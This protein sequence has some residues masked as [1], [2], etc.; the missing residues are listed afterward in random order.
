MS[1]YFNC[2]LLESEKMHYICGSSLT[3]ISNEL[4]CAGSVYFE[5]TVF[6][7]SAGQVILM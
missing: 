2:E 7:Y 6:T 5:Q 3:D 4:H 1:M